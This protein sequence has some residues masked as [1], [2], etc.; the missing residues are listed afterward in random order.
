M[1]TAKVLAC[2]L[3]A[4]PLVGTAPPAVPNSRAKTLPSAE[5]AKATRARLLAQLKEG[6]ELFRLD[7]YREAAERFESLRKAALAAH[8]DDL[9]ARAIGDIGSTQFALH[10]YQP[11]LRSYLEAQ[12]I[13]TAAHD[14]TST[15]LFA[16]NI[17]SLYSEMGALD[18][19]AQWTQGALE[20]LSGERRREVMPK[21][22]FETAILRARQDRM[23][24]AVK[25]FGQGIDAADRE[26]LVELSAIGWNRAGEEFLKRGELAAAEPA[27][28]EAYRLR[29]LNHLTLGSCYRNL[30]RLRLEQGDLA[31]A[32]ALLDR[33]VEL[34]AGPRG[35]IP[36][37]DVYHYRGKVRLAQGRL[38]DAVSD[39]RISVRLARDWR[40]SIPPD[41]ASRIG[42]EGWL[43]LVHAAMVEAGNRLYLQTGDAALIGET[44]EAAEENRASSL[45]ALVSSRH[46]AT[47]DDLPPQYWE[48]LKR[49]QR[50][51]V[52]ALR[53]K[54]LPTRSLATRSLATSSLA[55]SSLATS[56]L[57]TRDPRAEEASSVIRAELIRMETG[58]DA[59]SAPLPT[60]LLRKAQAAIDADSVLFS[61][62]LGDSVSWMWALDNHALA[63]Y[64]LPPRKQIELEVEAA[65]RAVRDDTPGASQVSAKLY[66]T[67]FGELGARF[68]RKTRWL[69]ALDHGMFDAPVAAL[70][71]SGDQD[72]GG[73]PQPTYVVEHHVIE[74]IPGVGYWV[75]SRARRNSQPG[76]EP[77]SPLFVGV[78][79]PVYNTADPRL[80][81]N[82]HGRA[83]LPSLLR[84]SVESGP[85]VLP[86]LVASGV[87]LDACA[88]IWNG[89]H[90]LLRGRDASRG[91]LL[92]Q[93]RRNPAVVHFATHVVESSERPASG[94]IALSLTDR[95]EMELLT[96]V[97]IAHFSTHAGL[98]VLSGCHSAAG[99]SLPGTGLVGLTRAWLLAGAQSVVSSNWDTTDESG[100]LFRAL[101]ANLGDSNRGD[102]GR[103]Q[104]NRGG[105]RA[106]PP[107]ALREAQLDMIR[108][109]GWRARP[110][111]WGAYSV[112]GNL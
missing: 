19:A 110:R 111:Y 24:E 30:G 9:A 73:G 60:D 78:G 96:P 91:R 38:R 76:I 23:P 93:L 14:P 94:M 10:Q 41:D 58:R 65:A 42:A 32:S 29:K 15:A 59:I 54:A 27:L 40:W 69:I 72:G 86:R 97:E 112:V 48:M 7:R 81:G 47:G 62:H 22:L 80:A 95:N 85:L 50:A 55:T 3:L 1:K 46:T 77:A 44:F 99:A 37:W 79:D 108:S 4:F 18:T 57:P 34:S 87:E 33:A 16:M 8:V 89:E 82:R 12:R 49:L 21:L 98:V 61:F 51:E 20:R 17:A 109:G 13:A 25:M 53:T 36:S 102:L 63:L 70:I 35:P 39:L 45:R 52:E 90:T 6:L 88:R 104:L 74:F 101:Y 103:G 31:S 64:A 75:E 84:T 105:R 83:W 107:R 28:L 67:L 71:D 92:E 56:L 43:Q 26:G 5:E 66:R 68:Q 2:C 106:D 100:A 11:A